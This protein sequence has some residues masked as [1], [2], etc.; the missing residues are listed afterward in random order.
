MKISIVK[1]EKYEEACMDGVWHTPIQVAG[2]HTV[3]Y[4][5]N[6]PSSLLLSYSIERDAANIGIA[7]PQTTD[8]GPLLLDAALTKLR[9]LNPNVFALF[10]YTLDDGEADRLTCNVASF[11][12]IGHFHKVFIDCAGIKR[13]VQLYCAELARPKEGA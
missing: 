1:Q 3:L 12:K 10:T 11:E 6:G 5:T 13:D 4:V 7:L 8:Q 9:Q 2:K